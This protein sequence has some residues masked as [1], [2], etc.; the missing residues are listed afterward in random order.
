MVSVLKTPGVYREE[1]SIFPPSVAAVETAIPAFIGHT[2]KALDRSAD[3]TFKAEK[4]DSIA[5][6][7]EKFGIGP[8][9]VVD[10]VHVQLD[11]SVAD[12]K[13]NSNYYL[14]DSLSLFYDNGGG[15]CFVVSIGDFDEDV[16]AENLKKGLKAVA[17]EDQP[18]MLVMPDAIALGNDQFYGVQQAALK[19]CGDLQDRFAIL[20]LLE[21]KNN[22]ALDLDESVEEFRNE[23][24]TSNLKYGA[25]YVPHL[26]A[27]LPKTVT[28]RNVLGKLQRQGVLLDAG[29]LVPDSAQATLLLASNAIEDTNKI[30]NA[31]AAFV[32]ANDGGNNDI[33]SIAQVFQVASDTFQ[34][35][36]AK[37]LSAAPSA[38]Q[39][40]A[41]GVAFRELFDLTY[42]LIQNTIDKHAIPDADNELTV[43]G[44]RNF[45]RDKITDLLLGIVQRL[46]QITVGARALTGAPADLNKRYEDF[47]VVSAEWEN[48]FDAGLVALVGAD[49][50]AVYPRDMQ[51]LA[52]AAKIRAQAQNMTSAAKH[53]VTIFGT[54]R[55]SAVAILAKAKEVEA[56]VNDA[57]RDSAPLLRNVIDR[58]AN[59]QSTLPP[60]GVIAGI[61][62]QVD[63]TRGVFK[64]PAN[65][66]LSNISA[67]TTIISHVVQQDLNV[68]TVA[69][70]SINA[71]RPFLGRG[72][73]VWGAR[74]LDGNSNEWRYIS[75]RRFF[76]MVEESCKNASERF[77]FEPNDRN[78]WVKIRGMIDNFLLIQ[79]RIGALQGAVPEHAFFVKVGLGETMTALDILEGRMIVEIGM[80]VVRPAEFI[81]LRFSHRMPIS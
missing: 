74:T 14:Y 58:V 21:V 12:V 13:L 22:V 30:R 3:L 56:Q 25:A 31:I 53:V 70:K 57:L 16:S 15:R 46:N 33:K 32:S 59:A 18:T 60:S 5:E 28:F 37:L 19:Q 64:A 77:V 65:V 75:V 7:R 52:D 78:T 51:G 54:L 72:K 80:A 66:S 6:F 29:E 71:I 20:D 11:S 42:Q 38:N 61:Y 69:G 39:L 49:L 47:P 63:R 2:E 55:E 40:A 27:N 1:V 36:S 10:S 68:D 45:A 23:I 50:L 8:E 24:G 4:I 44:N 43:D 26:R 35:E 81:I 41:T 73:L 76:N 79:W 62:S 17:L 9:V 67:L 48:A 34:S